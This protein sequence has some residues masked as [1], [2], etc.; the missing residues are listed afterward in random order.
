MYGVALATLSPSQIFRYWFIVRGT[1][2]QNKKPKTVWL[3]QNLLEFKV[4]VKNK[5]SY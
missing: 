4:R 5:D 3:I 2:R 1:R